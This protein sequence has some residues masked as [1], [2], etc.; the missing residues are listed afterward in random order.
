MQDDC[1]FIITCIYSFLL[2]R[3]YCPDS[4]MKFRLAARLRGR[5]HYAWIVAAL[6]FLTLLAVAGI[7]ATPSVLIVPLEHAFGWGRDQITLAVSI[8]LFLFVSRARAHAHVLAAVPDLLR[9]RPEHE[10]S[11]RH[12]SDR[13]LRRQR[14][15]RS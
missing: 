13:I 8:G 7:R 12:A 6:T 1:H 11:D 9:L 5:V 14:H 3:K 15:P 2:L 10:W 4:P